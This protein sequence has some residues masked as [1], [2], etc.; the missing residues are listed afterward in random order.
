[1]TV[2]AKTLF[3]SSRLFSVRNQIVAVLALITALPLLI[4][5]F[6]GLRDL[7]ARQVGI[8]RNNMLSL[9]T[10]EASTFSQQLVAQYD[11]VEL[12]SLVDTLEQFALRSNASYEQ[13]GRDIKTVLDERDFLWSSASDVDPIVTAVLNN[14]ASSELQQFQQKHPGHVEV[15][16]T[17][18]FGAVIAATGRTTDYNQ[19]D[20]DWWRAAYDG[21][22][23][24]VYIDERAVLDESTGTLSLRMAFPVFSGDS[25]VGVLRTTFEVNAFVQVL[26]SF[27]FG[28]SSYSVAVYDT[29]EVIAAPVSFPSDYRLSTRLFNGSVSVF[30]NSDDVITDLTGQPAVYAVA[31][32]QTGGEV[33]AIDELG[34]YVALLL[35]QSELVFARDV[36]ISEL[37]LPTVVLLLVALVV[38]YV[39]AGTLTRPLRK[40]VLAARRIG[41][42]RDWQ[43][44][45]DL[46]R[47]DEFGVLGEAFNTMAAQLQAVFDD[48]ERRISARTADLETSA[49]IASSANQIRELDD[50]M[51]LAV[52]L[53]RDRFDL[54][55][56]QIYLIDA[57][58]KWAVLKD[59]TG[60]VGRRLLVQGHRLPLDGHSLVS[61]AY[62]SGQAVVVQ[63]VADNPHFLPNDL[64]PLTRSELA[65]PLRSK[66]AVIGILDIQHSV[67]DAFDVPS[68]RLF[69]SLA[70][71]LAIT[72][73]NVKLYEDTQRRALEMETVAEVSAEAAKNLNLEDLLRAVSNLTRDNFDLYHAHIY[74]LDDVGENL[75][76]AGGA[77]EVGRVMMER[78]HKIAL[79][80][81]HS[82]VAR[83]ARERQPVIIND[84]TSEP[85]H[86]PNPLLP[87]TKSE[88]AIPMLVGDELVGVLDVQSAERG[89]F[90]SND[91][92]VQTTLADQIAI[93]VQN[94]R[95]FARVEAARKEVA[96]VYEMSADMIGSADFSGFFLDL[97]PAWERTL[98]WTIDEL[99]AKPFIEFVHP[100]DR[101]H[102]LDEYTAQMSEGRSSIQF[103]N[104][105][106]HK[107]G[108]Y[109][110]LSWNATSVMA[111]ERTYF[112]TRDVTES[113][114][115]E[116]QIKLFADVVQASPTGIYVWHLENV[117]DVNSFRLVVA[118]DATQSATGVAPQSI[119]GKTMPEAFG[120]LMDTPIPGIYQNVI[121]TGQPVEL[122]E[123]V[124]QDE[125][126]AP[127]VFYVRAF[128]LPNNSVGVSFENITA[129][130]QQ[131]ELIAKRAVELETV[132][133]AGAA[134]TSFLQLDELLQSVVELTKDSFGLYHAHI[135]LLDD[136][137]EE[138]ILKAGA[139]E[140][141][142]I[143]VERGHHISIHHETSIVAQ[144]ARHTSTV[145]VNDVTVSATFLPNPLLPDTKSELAIPLIIGATVIGVLDV[146]SDIVGRFSE[147]DENVLMILASQ[148]AVA[149]QNAHTYEQMQQTR[150]S[151]EANEKR[152]NLALTGTSDGLWDWDLIT[153]EV[154]L[155][156]RW[157]QMLGY[158]DHELENSFNTWERLV[159]PEDLF[160]AQNAISAYLEGR[161]DVYEI[162][163]RMMH[164]DGSLRWILSR[165]GAERDADGNMI[166][167]VGTHTDITERMEE[168][169]QRQILYRIANAL[170]NAQKPEQV[171]RAINSFAL[172]YEVASASLFYVENDESGQPEWIEAKAVWSKPDY[173]PLSIGTRFYLPDLPFSKV[174]LDNPEE[175]IFIEDVNTHP[176]VDEMTR[177]LYIQGGIRSSVI[178]PLYSQNRYTGLVVFSWREPRKFTQFER[179]IYTSLRQQATTTVDII[180]ANVA[181]LENEE[182]LSSI[183][184]NASAI[185]HVKGRDGK[186]LLIN[187]AYET[188]FKLN[189]A[190]IRG[191]TDFDIFPKE[192]AETLWQV[193]R[194]IINS[195]IVRELIETL[196]HPDGSSHT[197]ISVKFPLRD[198]NGEIYAVGAMSTDITDRVKA[199]AEIQRRATEMETVA[200]VSLNLT[201]NRNLEEL[202]WSVVDMTK[203][204]FHRYHA[205]IYLFDVASEDL[206]LTAGAGEVGRKMVEAGHRIPLDRETSL[207]ARAARTCK[208][209]IVDD[210][211]TDAGFLPNPLLPNTLSELAVPII[212]NDELIG[213]LDIQDDK[214]GAFSEI[215]AQVKLTLANQIAV[216]INNA[217]A[218]ERERETVERLREVD[219]LKQQFLANM[220]HELRTPLNSIIGYAEVLLDGVDGEL[221][222]E[223]I[224]DVEA[225]HGSGKHLL[226]LINE[227]L[228]LAKI[229]AGQMRLDI[230]EVKIED[231]IEELVRSSQILVKD[232]PVT[233]QLIKESDEIPTVRADAVRLRQIL[234]NL[235]SNAIKFT[236]EGSV[237]VRY[238]VSAEDAHK[239]FVAVED[240][241]IGMG[242]S[243]LNVIFDRFRQADG[244]STR[245]AGGT[246]LGLAITR[247]L[248]QMHGGD[249]FVESEPG[250]GSKFWFTLPIPVTE[251]A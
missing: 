233:L 246:G 225:I 173:S 171:L 178:I 217:R 66:E 123:V 1:M 100:D 48:L 196:P 114:A 186:Y 43:T 141:G 172:D 224:E 160:D 118:N 238:G 132:A 162:E 21:G 242:H 53:I 181:L 88:M 201:M 226:T 144:A 203:E 248:V 161:S 109:R 152:L 165:G 105:Y 227:I 182:R 239:L 22:S 106:L 40:L 174:W 70:D 74:L 54:Y 129:R 15:F 133:M 26:E 166:R 5:L 240:T 62:H 214:R 220:S 179:N 83:A 17:D 126:I 250:V 63:N 91:V 39:I 136:E 155:S 143:M 101:Q 13:D 184:N 108:T 81:E 232:K 68:Q 97:N 237:T 149:I 111:E 247:E 46:R 110:W 180:R 251:K 87:E 59:G 223:A 27:R 33:P 157:K 151:L 177:N 138:L 183:L 113:R 20:E 38:G 188:I 103:M 234:L 71:Q 3:K 35:P 168:S 115:A 231:I 98:G 146:Q 8:V 58:Q 187:R 19:S 170:N 69:Q 2:E 189:N 236:E 104:R 99:K 245:R 50:L 79:N 198:A 28:E 9:I 230:K 193:D 228:D 7:S 124:Y 163:M 72:F 147:S 86:L 169:E 192:V 65:I 208:P 89:R 222:D 82:L 219:R 12:L 207:V 107:D 212:Y 80:W 176:N 77:G 122:G 94:A 78:G 52:N 125:N 211:T 145:V 75:T 127:S 61:Q 36:A 73:E 119:L 175:P 90:D 44:R 140:P 116:E 49:E 142:R 41:G 210:V 164:K 25:L 195:G 45:I 209:V 134:V 34:W 244:S 24:A 235:M 23:G 11:Y 215:E 131:E 56:V 154:Y 42:E 216:A 31:P 120:P 14:V 135:Y 243:D 206:I 117:D 112:V 85:D 158:E 194:E 156:P 37:L 249:I 29:G 139:G 64:L 148:I 199:Q 159:Y 30:S 76:L 241:G 4:T 205:H 95:A 213:V 137:G 92:R 204:N 51:S 93:A 121:K 6:F 16:L 32:I 167:L 200:E 96:R 202:L 229:D 102:T 18:A 128:P 221:S 150:Q 130:K 185:I 10:S 84:V 153:N 191:K 197:Y 60:Y 190:E 218:F 47:N 57:E 55:Y 67:L